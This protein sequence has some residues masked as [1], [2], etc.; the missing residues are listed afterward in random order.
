MLLHYRL[1]EGKEEIV[2]ATKLEFVYYE[3]R[4]AQKP[5]GFGKPAKVEIR[6]LPREMPSL[7]DEDYRKLKFKKLSSIRF[8]YRE[9]EGKGRLYL[10]ATPLSKKKAEVVWPAYRL[11]NTS[12]A[13]APHFRGRV[14][15]K[16]VDLALPPFLEEKTPG[17]RILTSID[18]KFS[19]QKKRRDWF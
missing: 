16:L 12:V 3:R 9:E 17:K 8:E 11:R 14:E 6:D 10:V 5:T 19:G 18:F 15:G 2:R 7:Q 13:R 1:P 4:I